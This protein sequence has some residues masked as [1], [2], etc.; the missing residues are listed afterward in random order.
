VSSAAVARRPYRRRGGG[1]A[2]QRGGARTALAWSA[3]DTEPVRTGFGHGTPL[4]RGAMTV[5]PRAA[6]PGT[7]RGN[8]ATD[9]QAPPVSA[10]LFFRN[11]RKWLSTQGKWLQGEE[12]SEKIPDGRK[13]YLEQFSSLKP[14]PILPRF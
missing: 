2:G 9:R 5:P 14:L 1:S 7:M 8:L 4:W 13:S 12:K 10:F 6:N 11:T 3:S